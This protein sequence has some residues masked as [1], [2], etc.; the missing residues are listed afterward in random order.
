MP[1]IN[2]ELSPVTS[3]NHSSEIKST[4]PIQPFFFGRIEELR[5]IYD[6]LRPEYRSWGVM[7]AGPGGIGKTALAIQAAEQA[8]EELFEQ[9][10]FISA[11][12]RELTPAGEVCLTDFVQPT[13]F[14]ML[15]ELMKNVKN[16]GIVPD[17]NI[18]IA[19]DLRSLLMSK[20]ILI[21]FDNLETLE[22]SERERLY[23]FLSRLPAHNKAIVTCRRLS[24]GFGVKIIP[25]GYLSY[26]DSMKILLEY[27]KTH[28]RLQ[29]VKMEE[30]LELC[31]ITNGN[32]CLINW[33]AGQFGNENSS[34]YTLD[35]AYKLLKKNPENYPMEYV[36]GDLMDNMT[37]KELAILDALGWFETPAEIK[38]ISEMTQISVSDL[39]LILYDLKKR[40]IVISEA[41]MTLFTLPILAKSYMK[42]KG[43][44]NRKGDK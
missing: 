5:Q 10:I 6:T 9:K 4:L 16:D 21:I 13:F 41:E 27:K 23:Q 22:F 31:K 40:S 15:T 39:D 33:I 32:P 25:L 28:H 11:K 37:D 26:D 34:C 35:D 8:P 42:Q 43:A 24:I 1:T 12:I 36:F 7:I 29:K 38:W 14:G 20:K 44:Q 2:Q 30:L 19:S 3:T 17:F 18:N